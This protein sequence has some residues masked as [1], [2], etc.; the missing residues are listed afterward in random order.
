LSLL[1]HCTGSSN[2][3]LNFL[4]S[5]TASKGKQLAKD[6]P[7]EELTYLNISDL[8]FLKRNSCIIVIEADD[9][10]NTQ[11]YA[12][13]AF[14][15]NNKGSKKR[16]KAIVKHQG[17]EGHFIWFKL[18][19]DSQRQLPYLGKRMSEVDEYDINPD[20]VPQPSDPQTD[21]DEDLK[22]EEQKDITIIQALKKL[23]QCLAIWE[24]MT[25]HKSNKLCN[26]LKLIY[27]IF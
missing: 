20:N 14:L 24:R 3:R 2:I 6:Q 7:A 13:V 12:F 15:D 8:T 4:T 11:G 26:N 21:T 22:Q 5:T 9:K 27:D 23:S 18:C 25:W 19:H 1:Y 17:P 16:S 10:K